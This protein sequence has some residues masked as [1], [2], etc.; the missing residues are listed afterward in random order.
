MLAH[1]VLCNASVA[2][3]GCSAVAILVQVLTWLARVARIAIAAFP[4]R[5]RLMLPRHFCNRLCAL[6]KH[7]VFASASMFLGLRYVTVLLL[8]NFATLQCYSCS[9]TKRC[10]P[11][12]FQRRAQN[13][14]HSCHRCDF[15]KRLYLIHMSHCSN[16][17]DDS[18]SRIVPK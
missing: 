2:R 1:C 5:G 15:G 12:P 16:I 6:W 13:V 14:N 11:S 17:N 4:V 7:F 9:T 10:R 8:C 3:F 18:C